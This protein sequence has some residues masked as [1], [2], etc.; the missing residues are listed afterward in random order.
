M[1][2][3]IHANVIDGRGLGKTPF[4]YG[5]GLKNIYGHE[6][7]FLT[8][9]L[10]KN[11]GAPRVEKHFPVH[12]YEGNIDLTPKN[13]I[14][15][16]IEKIVNDEKIEF[17]HLLK[18]GENDNITPDNCKTGIHCVFN[19]CEQHGNVYAAVSQNLAN[20]YNSDLY[21]PHIIKRIPVTKDLRK[22]LNIPKDALVIGRHGGISTFDLAFVKEAVKEIVNK[23]KD[24]YFLFLSTEVFY[25]HERVIYFPWVSQEAGIFNFINACDIMLHARQMGETFG[26]SV[27]EFA[28]SNKPVMTW[29][30]M[31]QGSKQTVYDTAHID[32]LKGKAIIYNDGVDLL[33]TVM[34]LDTNY[35]RNN[36]W[37]T[38][39]SEFNETKVME[40]YNKVFLQ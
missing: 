19:M 40:Q 36:N 3:A 33:D 10:S 2:V 22:E 29:S 35:L 6:V 17:M 28:I 24:V 23:R 31:W 21:V 39:S 4:D 30:G 12:Y 32:H 13:V 15:S 34:N 14:K 26:L 5:L 20:K 25:S 27:A 8:S 11:D 38:I 1:K 7:C 9:K 18:A 37:D 16:Q